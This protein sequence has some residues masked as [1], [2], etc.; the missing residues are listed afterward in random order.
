MLI[1]SARD[2]E[3]NRTVTVPV[4]PAVA[5]PGDTTTAVVPQDAT[6]TSPPDESG[7]QPAAA[8]PLGSD[9]PLT[10]EEESSSDEEGQWIVLAELDQDER[11]AATVEV[12]SPTVTIS[13]APITTAAATATTERG[14]S[15]PPSS[16]LDRPAA[17]ENEDQHD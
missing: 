2:A 13:E 3:A 8:E 5:T 14:P 6:N 4:V 12:A 11:H 17:S 15:E 7:V 1:Q 16:I 9:A 10:L